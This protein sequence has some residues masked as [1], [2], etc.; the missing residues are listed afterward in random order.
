MGSTLIEQAFVKDGQ[1]ALNN[2][3]T[4]P[5]LTMREA[6]NV[7]SVLVDTGGGTPFG[8]GEPPIGPVGAAVGNAFAAATGRRIRT[9][10]MTPERVLEALAGSGS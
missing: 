3:E 2:F 1:L 8:M 7:R 5:L 4:Y 6:P 9:L 10:P